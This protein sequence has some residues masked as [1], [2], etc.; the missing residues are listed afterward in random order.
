M[1]ID[2]T[3]EAMA[4]DLFDT[5]MFNG[6]VPAFDT[7]M[8]RENARRKL[9]ERLAPFFNALDAIFDAHDELRDA[10]DHHPWRYQSDLSRLVITIAR[11]Q[12]VLNA[13][14][15]PIGNDNA[16]TNPS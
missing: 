14:L 5:L 6:M 8:M 15:A 4:K 11:E 16:P 1:L 7:P 12:S 3:A 9:A 10:A 2:L 13:Q